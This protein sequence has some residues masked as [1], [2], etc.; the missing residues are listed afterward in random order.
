[1]R[2]DD[3]RDDKKSYRK[4]NRESGESKHIALLEGCRVAGANR[5][6]QLL[7]CVISEQAAH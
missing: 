4:E 2:A 6:L 3:G 1:L 5:P 7:N